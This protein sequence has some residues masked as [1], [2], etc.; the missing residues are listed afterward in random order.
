MT[1]GR[2]L[3]GWLVPRR[4]AGALPVWGRAKDALLLAALI[5]ASGS[6]VA[7]TWTV[8][9]AWRDNRAI[10][11]LV[12]GRDLPADAGSRLE[13]QAARAYFLLQHDRIEEA[14]QLVSEI[15]AT[16]D[17]W[18]DPQ[19][20]ADLQYNLANARMRAAI[21]LI[22]RD[23]IDAATS[24]VSL[25]KD[26]YRATLASD[27]GYWDARYNLDV[28]MR[29]LR[30]FSLTEQNSEETSQQPPKRLWTDLPGTPKGL[31]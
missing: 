17:P 31:P 4:F 19:L 11:D 24:F 29:L 5:A 16:R 6:F 2:W 10:A 25:A 23:R 20:L 7:S 27:P 22:E 9:A 13:V 14:Q 21:A 1:A 28:A 12:A 3:G 8:L 15:K 18:P 30:D 26:G